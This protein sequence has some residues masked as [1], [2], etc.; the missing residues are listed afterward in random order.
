MFSFFVKLLH[1]E[2]LFQ[3]DFGNHY[4]SFQCICKN[5][6]SLKRTIIDS[7]VGQ[8]F[9]LY[10]KPV[11]KIFMCENFTVVIIYSKWVVFILRNIYQFHF[12]VMH[13]NHLKIRRDQFH[14]WKLEN[15]LT[16]CTG[17]NCF[18]WQKF[19][20]FCKLFLSKSFCMYYAHFRKTYLNFFKP[21]Y[22]IL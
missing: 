16:A 6:T 5:Y 11:E 1:Q 14:N 8:F 18:H 20:K 15:A 12:V 19:T 4:K 21:P 10:I 7:I 22:S 17:Q 9:F 2:K 13:I 3:A